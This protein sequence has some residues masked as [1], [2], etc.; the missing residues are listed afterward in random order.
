M[1]R[2]GLN[3]E[4]IIKNDIHE[5]DE[6]TEEQV[7]SILLVE[8]KDKIKQR[9]F[10][11]LNF[12]DRSHKELNDRLRKLGFDQFLIDEAMQDLVADG[13]LNDERFIREFVSDYTKLNP[14]GNRYISNELKKKG[15]TADAIAQALNERD[16]K[17]LAKELLGT[18]L[19]GLDRNDPKD[20]AKIVRRLMSRGFT[21][22]VIYE[23]LGEKDE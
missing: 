9:A 18:K 19:A 5:G 13:T 4:V 15:I 2:F 14:R 16:E 1:Y 10:R 3:N 6:I 11:I 12:R 7:K 20:R 8:E 21:P 17:S 23:I 22:S